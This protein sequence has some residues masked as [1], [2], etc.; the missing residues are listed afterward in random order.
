MIVP[1]AISSN[2]HA[3]YGSNAVLRR[4]DNCGYFK[5][6]ALPFGLESGHD[7]G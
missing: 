5:A 7:G 4:E 3:V 2:V 1:P 6:H